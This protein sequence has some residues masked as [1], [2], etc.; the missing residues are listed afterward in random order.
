MKKFIFTGILLTSML[1]SA[2]GQTVLINETFEDYANGA[3]L[4]AAAQAMGRD[5]WRAWNAYNVNE[6]ATIV[7]EQHSGGAQSAKLVKDNDVVLLLGNKTSGAYALDFKMYVPTGQTGYFNIL[8]K[9]PV[10]GNGHEWAM[11]IYFNSNGTITLHADQQ[12]LNVGT[13]TLATWLNIGLVFDLDEDVAAIAVNGTTLRTWKFSLKPGGEQ[14]TKQL[15]GMDLYGG[16][17]SHVFN[18]YID[19]VVFKQTSDPLPLPTVTFTGDLEKKIKPGETANVSTFIN[20]EEP[21]T[22]DAIWSTLIKYPDLDYGTQKDF[23]LALCDEYSVQATLGYLATSNYTIEMAMRLTPNDYKDKI[24]GEINKIYYFVGIAP[25]IPI[26]DLTFRVYG[27]GKTAYDEGEILAEK[28]LPLS[29]MVQNTWNSVTLDEGVKLNGGEYWITVE[30][31]CPPTVEGE[32]PYPLS[33]D[34]GPSAWGGDWDRRN[35]G[36]WGRVEKYGN[37]AIKADCSGKVRDAFVFADQTFGTTK[38]EESTPVIFN[39][40]TGT[41]PNKESFEATLFITSN[42]EVTPIIEIPILMIVDDEIASSDVRVKEV[43]VNDSIAKLST[44]PAYDYRVSIKTDKYFANIVVTTEH[45]AATVT[46]DGE[47]PIIKGVNNLT[48]TV[49]AEDGTTT[50]DYILRILADIVS[51]S[52]IESSVQFYP[53]P[54]VDYLYLKS[55]IAI[56]Q[57]TIFDLTGKVVKQIKQPAPSIDLSDLSAGFY[58]LQVNTAEGASTQRFVKE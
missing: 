49:T 8:H 3:K 55:D 35:K 30:F 38:A 22:Q 12:N 26:G 21:E 57:V 37:F 29:Q 42:D 31:E 28:V 44:D 46:G 34:A 52:E 39:F 47:Q 51:I 53:N 10:N 56:E 17:N 23:T 58:L 2:L 11:E 33:M 27:Q 13:F 36:P 1:F 43:L 48:F 20:S 5:Y 18:Y 25:S 54:V 9:P 32:G 16:D 4:V 6:D 50:K 41:Y 14:G 40:Q 15:G 45:P 19:D 7:T 24:G